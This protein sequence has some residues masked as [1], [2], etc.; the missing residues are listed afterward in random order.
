MNPTQ[1]NSQS[2]PNGLSYLHTLR[3]RNTQDITR[4]TIESGA[5]RDVLAAWN[6]Q[7]REREGAA[8]R[9]GFVSGYWVGGWLDVNMETYIYM[10]MY[11]YAAAT[12][13][14]IF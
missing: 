3:A 12:S 11:R 2:L 8:A 5:E 4:W 9:E 1:P 10:H 6:P 14:R 7:Q 13:P